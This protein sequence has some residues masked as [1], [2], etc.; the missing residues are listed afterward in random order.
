MV[1]TLKDNHTCTKP[2][3]IKVV[4]STQIA[5]KILNIISVDLNKSRK[6]LDTILMEMYGIKPYPV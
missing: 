2:S 6:A 1:K 3:I 4:N 5:N